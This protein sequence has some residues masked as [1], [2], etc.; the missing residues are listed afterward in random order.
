MVACQFQAIS[1]NRAR[2][3]NR[4]ALVQS[5]EPFC[6]CEV[7]RRPPSSKTAKI[8]ANQIDWRYFAL[9][10]QETASVLGEIEHKVR[11]TAGIPAHGYEPTRGCRA[12]IWRRAASSVDARF[13]PSA[14][15][16]GVS[17]RRSEDCRSTDDYALRRFPLPRPDAVV[18]VAQ[19]ALLLTYRSPDRGG[20]WAGRFRPNREHRRQY[21]AFAYRQGCAWLPRNGSAPISAKCCSFFTTAPPFGNHHVRPPSRKFGTR[22][23]GSIRMVP[24]IATPITKP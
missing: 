8:C 7:M 14:A 20:G 9:D 5:A 2:G 1:S 24:L 16:C 22:S 13:R 23:Y 18:P 12:L 19:D 4:A 10:A 3:R 21:A 6:R 17:M 15:T 11:L